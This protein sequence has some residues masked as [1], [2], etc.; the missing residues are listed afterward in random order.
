MVWANTIHLSSLKS[1]VLSDI[2][3][4]ICPTER[5]THGLS[6]VQEMK[7]VGSK[8]LTSL[9]RSTTELLQD[10]SS[11]CRL[12]IQQCPQLLCV[13][14]GEE[15][16]QQQQLGMPCRLEYLELNE[17]M[18]FEK[19]PKALCSLSFLKEIYI[20][21]CPKLV[22]FPEISMPPKLRI[23]GI[24]KCNALKSLPEAWMNSNNTYL[25]SL[26]IKECDS[27]TYIAKFRLPLNLKWLSISCCNSLCTLIDEEET[28]DSETNSNSS[29]LE[30]LAMEYCPSLTSL[31]SKSELPDTLEHIELSRCSNLASL[32][33]RGNLPMA[34]KDLMVYDCSKL[35]SI[36]ERL[37]NLT[38]LERI[39]ISCCDNLA[40]LP[41]DLHKLRHLQE[42]T[43]SR[44]PNLVSFPEG[45]LPSGNLKLLRIYSCEKLKALPN[46]IHNLT[47]LKNLSITDCPSM[48][49]F[50][51]HGFPISL[52]SLEIDDL[53]IFKPL[54]DWGLYRLTSLRDLRIG[55]GC[56]EVV[57]FPQEE[58]GMMLP[59]SLTHLKIENFPNL[60]RLSS[61]I[62]NLT[63]LEELSLSACPKLKFLPEDGLPSSLLKLNINKCP[64]LKQMCEKHR[65]QNYWPMIA[66]IPYVCI[67]LNFIPAYGPPRSI[68]I[69]HNLFPRRQHLG[70]FQIQ[71]LAQNLILEEQEQAIPCCSSY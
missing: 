29:L 15:Q 24:A 9:W 40:C 53:D 63:C 10:N 27:L 7:I 19:L 51:V 12:V 45:D 39:R 49:L 33:S 20:Q 64:L 58:I 21:D 23:I 5:L 44:C 35:E 67:D 26:S 68:L 14:A 65:G 47:A 11:L 52:A 41:Q 17:C 38:S 66:R 43:I 25:A 54:F 48:A 56:P 37:L 46:R 8:E 31:W 60:E 2:S 57:S 61:D 6:K 3:T 55:K 13:V 50:P 4:H 70:P 30:Y 28:T 36:A 1:V 32:S 18:R 22:S 62:Q 71:A 16:Q 42:M 59:T 34:L 69:S